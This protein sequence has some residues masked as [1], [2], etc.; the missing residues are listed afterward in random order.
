MPISSADC[1][2]WPT[3][4]PPSK[5]LSGALAGWSVEVDYR[6]RAADLARDWDARV[7]A[8]YAA[9]HGPPPS[10]AEVIGAV[11]E[12][13]GPRDVV[14][15]AA[16]SLP[17]D[18]H[19]LWRCRDPKGFHVEYGYSCM[20]YEIAGGL[21][22][23]L[24]APDREVYVIVG[25]GSWLMMSSEIVT[26]LQEHAK[27]IV[28]L[29]DNHGFASIGGLSESLGS[30]G[31]G[32]RYRY[33]EGAGMDLDGDLLRVDF[34]ANAASLGA[35]A[36]RARTI[37]D[38]GAALSEA[39]G[40][41]P[42]GR[43][44]DR[45][46]SEGARG[47][48]RDVV[49]RAGRRD[50]RAGA[51]RSG[52][53]AL[54]EGTLTRTVADMTLWTH[55]RRLALACLVI[56][57]CSHA[58]ELETSPS[59]GPVES[60]RPALVVMVVVDQLSQELLDRYDDVFTGGFRRLIDGGRWYVNATHDHAGTVTAAGHATLSTGSYPSHHG[61]VANEWFENVDG[62]WIE[63]SNV[64]DST[65]QI[66]GYPELEGVSP[67]SLERTGLADWIVAAEPG[68]KVVSVSPKDR[69]AVLPAAHAR[70]QVWWFDASVGRFVT[71]T[72]Y[73]DSNPEWI[74]RFHDEV[75]APLAAD[76]VWA[77]RVPAALLGRSDPDTRRLRGRQRRPRSF[78][79]AS[80]GRGSAPH[81]WEWFERTPMLDEATLELA[82]VIVDAEGLGQDSI[83][84]FLGVS[85]SQ[86]DRVG[87]DF[88]PLSREQLDNLLRLD[89]ELGAF[90]AFL[91]SV[92]GPGRWVLGLSADHGVLVTG[93]D[94]RVGE[95]ASA[96][97]WT[98]EEEAALAEI[99]AE[100]EEAEGVTP[101]EVAAALEELDYVAEAW[102]HAELSSG[103]PADSF[104]ELE[105]H[106][107]Y[108]G[109]AREEISRWGVEV[110]FDPYFLDRE[111][112]SGHGTPY[113]YDRNVPLLFYG[114]GVTAGRDSTRAST[115]DFAPT[116][117][118]LLGIPFPQDLDGAPLG[119]VVGD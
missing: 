66:V 15:C 85:L 63:I 104:A 43:D 119:G 87:H 19:K 27:L 48:V 61:I 42:H 100:A 9:G 40:I 68:A 39:K 7:A 116:L 10:Q 114:P 95:S 64:G 110:R 52:A 11:N 76:S 41:D 25:D 91:D 13:A 50:Q 54:R 103:A 71:S 101:T 44:H 20:G 24:A 16:G 94:M 65:V 115:V 49:E 56:V 102:T 70:G 86:T 82:R 108:P 51:G 1:R 117:A 88:G 26:S 69:G 22:V 21:G 111:L 3:R 29:I 14:V 77:S 53:C 2:S 38:L 35:H 4:A 93:H 5:R 118:R 92:A 32:T 55:R 23:K 12:A 67:H 73:R 81:F 57:A 89:A 8:L 34:A 59:A 47:I 96:R 36:I 17:G 98:A 30:G 97:R 74:D 60:E 62:E 90:F 80:P 18:L 84:D 106:S 58:E 31:F 46:R 105:R 113:W 33:R 75:L 72:Y 79:T 28:V 45:N 99:Q 78:P 83:P 6:S 37:A 109:R 107:L 112:G